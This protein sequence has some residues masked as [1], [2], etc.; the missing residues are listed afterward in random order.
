MKFEA[1]QSRIEKTKPRHL[2]RACMDPF[3]VC[4]WY[5]FKTRIINTI[6]RILNKKSSIRYF[7]YRVGVLRLG[8]PRPKVFRKYLRLHKAGN[9]Y[10]N[11]MLEVEN[12]NSLYFCLT[13]II[14]LPQSPTHLGSTFYVN[15]T[16]TKQEVLSS[17]KLMRETVTVHKFP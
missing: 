13:P 11:K 2:Q 14:V 8:Y 15:S 1:F 9:L 16:S 7:F 10:R 6:P 12:F 5:H 17:R 3:Q 4:R